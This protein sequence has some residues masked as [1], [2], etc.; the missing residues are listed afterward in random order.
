[1]LRRRGWVC[2]YSGYYAVGLLPHP[3]AG[4]ETLTTQKAGPRN[5]RELRGLNVVLCLF[6]RVSL[7]G[8]LSPLSLWPP[9][10]AVAW[11]HSRCCCCCFACLSLSL[12]CLSPETTKTKARFKPA[13]ESAA[14]NKTVDLSPALC[15]ALA[16]CRCPAGVSPPNLHPQLG[17]WFDRHTTYPSTLRRWSLNNY[18]AQVRPSPDPGPNSR[19]SRA[20][21]YRP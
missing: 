7:T 20:Q 12:L 6:Q 10:I 2:Y 11:K 21:A 5:H 1:M 3:A 17:L 4:N 14:G 18:A 15:A 13:C 19:S 8:L 9:S 16:G